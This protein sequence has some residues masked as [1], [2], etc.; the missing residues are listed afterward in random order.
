[1]KGFLLA[2]AQSYMNVNQREAS[3]MC[4]PPSFDM[5]VLDMH[6]YERL[7][8]FLLL[9]VRQNLNVGEGVA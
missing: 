7:I 6:Q 5:Y 9:F 1:M 2:S 4:W 8:P 3:L